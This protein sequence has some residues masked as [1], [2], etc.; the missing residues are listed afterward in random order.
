MN[1]NFV[2]ANT[3]KYDIAKAYFEPLGKDFTLK[4]YAINAPEW[5]D[6]SVSVIAE[7]SALWAAQQIGEPCITSDA[8]LYI[9]TLGGFPGPFV[10]YV[11]DWLGQEGYLRLL[12]GQENRRAY[13]EGALSI[14]FPGGRVKTFTSRNYGTLASSASSIGTTWAANALFIPDGYTQTLG[15]MTNDEQVAY[16]GD[17]SWPDVVAYL[18][19]Q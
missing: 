14:A 8:G 1:I 12:A 2:T 16:W 4:Q 17:G 7:Q 10:K 19:E 13:F 18:R 3:L 11:N 9:E 15:S 5:Q 6:T